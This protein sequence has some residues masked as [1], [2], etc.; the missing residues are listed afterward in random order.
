[1]FLLELDGLEIGR[2]PAIFRLSSSRNFRFFFVEFCAE[3]LFDRA[4][5]L[6][7][8]NFYLAPARFL[9]II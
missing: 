1:M 6:I 4:Q 7:I 5:T 8:I 9:L 2:D 3:E